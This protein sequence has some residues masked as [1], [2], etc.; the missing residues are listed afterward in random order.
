MPT[1]T[2]DGRRA[3]HDR[4]ADDDGD[5]A[6]LDRHR[7]DAGRARPARLPD[8]ARRR[9]AQRAALDHAERRRRRRSHP[10]RDVQ[11]FAAVPRPRRPGR[12]AGR[13]AG[14]R[15]SPR[16][17]CAARARSAGAPSSAIAVEVGRQLRGRRAV[18]VR[19][20]RRHRQDRPRARA[21][22]TFYD[23]ELRFA[24]RLVGDVLDVL[25]PGAVLLVTADHGQVRR[26]RPDH[27]ARRRSC[28]RL[29]ASQSGEG[30]FRWLHAQPRR[31]RRAARRGAAERYGDVAWVV[32]REQV[33]DEQL[34]RPD[35]RRRRSPPASAT[36]PSSP[37]QPVSFHD[38]ADSGPFELVC[39]HGS[40]TSAE[41]LVPLARGRSR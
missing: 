36:S 3:D 29:V 35:D 24:D 14:H 22:A 31:G 9:G 34:V 1:L 30:R 28:W 40:L 27:R 37:T 21:S 13:A 26:R 41:M 6:E 2:L 19:L 4:R 16:P 20:L 5:R 39:R 23:A 11:P 8:D 7:A 32:T 18:R 17:T 15:R 38:P 33:I 25:P 10:P 12:V